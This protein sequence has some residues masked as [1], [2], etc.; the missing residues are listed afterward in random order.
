M[1]K[2]YIPTIS[3]HFWCGPGKNHQCD[4][5]GPAIVFKRDGTSLLESEAR[6]DPD[7]PKGLSGGSVS[8]SICGLDAM[9]MSYWKDDANV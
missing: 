9:S 7:F 6:K 5:A 2:V 8:C 3:N 1:S 4:T